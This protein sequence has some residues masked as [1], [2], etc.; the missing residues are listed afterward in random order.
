MS[1]TKKMNL[2]SWSEE[3]RPREKMMI[4]GREALSNSELLAILLG[5]GN[6]EQTA[7][8]LAKSVLQSVNGDLNELGRNSL[9][10]FM[11]FKGIGEAKSITI[12]AALELGRRRQLASPKASP[13]ITDSQAAYN[14]IAPII[15]DSQIEQFWVLLL[16]TSCRLLKKVKIGSGGVSSVIADP[17][18]IFKAAIENLATHVILI[19]NHPSGNLQ[20]SKQD[21]N[22]TNKLVEGAKYLDIR[23]QDHLIIGHGDYY[24]FNDEGRM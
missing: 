13:L 6:T 8:G 3:D 1:E 20:P 14:V 15:E 2:K 16:S 11:K 5:S 10:D 9:G 22:L 19:H 21:I 23:V 7:V 18:L 12:A 4:K 17:R 24:S